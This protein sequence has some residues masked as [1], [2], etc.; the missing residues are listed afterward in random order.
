MPSTIA[1]TIRSGHP[2]IAIASH[3]GLRDS[4]EDPNTGRP[5]PA[6]G[7]RRGSGEPADL[8]D[9]AERLEAEGDEGRR[10]DVRGGGGAAEAAVRNADADGLRGVAEV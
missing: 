1:N 2:G 6:Q 7:R 5:A 8:L 3:R 10:P 4:A 9:A